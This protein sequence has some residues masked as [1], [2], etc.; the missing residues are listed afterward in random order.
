MREVDEAVR[1]DQATDF[2]KKYGLPIGIAVAI[3]LAAFAGFLFWSNRSDNELEERSEQ[4][5]QAMDELEAGNIRIADGQFGTLSQG[6]DGAAAAA[7]MMQAGIALQEDRTAD[8]VTLY[9]RVANNTELPSELRDIATIRSVT[10][11]FDDLDP[12]TVIDRIGPLAQPDNAYYGSAGEMLAHAY[13]A[14]NRRDQ[15]GPLLVAISKND[16]V[17]ASIRGRT[18]QLAGLLGFDAIEDV[19]ATL[20]EL[21]GS[22][23]GEPTSD[24]VE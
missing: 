10:A 4:L 14:Q 12:Q 15:A 6:S 22:D 9:D 5:I 18:R 13:L 1:Q 20:D 11:Q 3:A 16:D 23:A 17:P 7:T 21:G 2:A 24:L 19:N 8:A